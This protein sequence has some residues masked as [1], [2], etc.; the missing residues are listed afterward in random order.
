V[1]RT[2]LMLALLVSAFGAIQLSATAAQAP[3]FSRVFVFDEEDGAVSGFALFIGA[4][5]QAAI[6]HD[7]LD[8]AGD[9]LESGA[10]RLRSL[11]TIAPLSPFAPPQ[12][13]SDT[14]ACR[15]D[16][17][18]GEEPTALPAIRLAWFTVEDCGAEGDP[19]W[20]V[21]ETLSIGCED[22]GTRFETALTGIDDFP[23]T[24]RFRTIVSTFG[25]S[26][27]N[28]D[29]G[30]PGENGLFNWSLYT[31][32][33]AGPITAPFPLPED[34]EVIVEF[35]LTD[36][37]GGPVVSDW[38]VEISKCNGGE[39]TYSGPAISDD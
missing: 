24:L 35:R 39:V 17:G 3:G 26:H 21:I 25:Q 8:A 20:R 32:D 18:G 34:T 36:G 38:V 1:K 23:T 28:E 16:W 15:V 2:F 4:Y 7:I 9:E 19:L 11:H 10:L 5:D 13:P 6:E 31:S 12:G 29:A 22:F 27:M 37:L 14:V 30:N 33:S